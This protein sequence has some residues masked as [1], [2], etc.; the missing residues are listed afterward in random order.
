MTVSIP[1]ELRQRL[2]TFGITAEDLEVL[3]SLRDFAEKTLPGLLERGLS[4]LASWPEA[5]AALRHPEVHRLRVA[6]WQRVATGQLDAGFLESAE[7]LGVALHRHGMPIY[8]VGLCGVTTLN[9]ISE[10]LGLNPPGPGWV[11][12]EAARKFALRLSLSHVAWLHCEL[13]LEC[14]TRA[15]KAARTSL[16]NRLVGTF[17]Q[18]MSGVV[19]ELGQSVRQ[20]EEAVQVIVGNAGRI[21]EVSGTVAQSAARADQD[22]QAAA[23]SAEQ[24]TN[25][26]GQISR[27]LG[28]ATRIAARAVEDARRTDTVVQALA[29]GAKRIDDVVSLINSI[30][31]QTNLLALNATIEAARAGEAGK[32]FA[33]VASEVKNLANQTAKATEEISGQIGQV[34]GATRE[35]VAA[36]ENIARTIDEINQIAAAIAEAVAQQGQTA[37]AIARTVQQ[38]A[39]GNRRVSEMMRGFEADASSARQ[40]AGQLSSAAGGLGG[41]SRSLRQAMDGFMSEVR[42]A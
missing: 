1:P 14:F 36:I 34:Q 9:L 23:S 39:A 18:R 21:G 6:H 35:A 28:E 5:M 37:D 12:R 26:V 7:A 40:V 42:S 15:E 16:T 20:M 31:G 13:L 11:R 8:G 25:S 30:A 33:V 2:S 32:G 22:V 38:A 41:H 3:P 10:E 19:E 17:E 24:L 29:E 27:Q 4:R